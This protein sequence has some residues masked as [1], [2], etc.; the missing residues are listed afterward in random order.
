MHVQSFVLEW[1][2]LAAGASDIIDIPIV[3]QQLVCH[4]RHRKW[5][6]LMPAML[7]I[8]DAGNHPSHLT[9]IMKAYAADWWTKDLAPR[10]LKSGHRTGKMTVTG[11]NWHQS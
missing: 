5:H 11:P 4:I 9:G 6:V 1:I 2:G 3:I 7:S 8:L 10:V